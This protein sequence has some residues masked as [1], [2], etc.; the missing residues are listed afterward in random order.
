MPASTTVTDKVTAITPIVLGDL[1]TTAEEKT[2]AEGGLQSTF[3]DYE[4]KLEGKRRNYL[5]LAERKAKYEADKSSA[6]NQLTTLDTIITA[7][8]AG[9]P[10][11]Q[12]YEDQKIKEQYKLDTAIINLRKYGGPATVEAY[13]ELMGLNAQALAIATGF[14]AVETHT[15]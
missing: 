8:G 6:E 10:A 12:S 15:I 14:N 13:H 5:S 7:V 11:A 3:D 1:I 4:Y 2:E 9:T